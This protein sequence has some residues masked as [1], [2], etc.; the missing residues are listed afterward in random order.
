MTETHFLYVEQNFT[1]VSILLPPPYPW[2]VP[3]LCCAFY[4][5]LSGIWN[6]TGRR[7]SVQPQWLH[8]MAGTMA[9]NAERM[10]DSQEEYSTM[11]VCSSSVEIGNGG[12]LHHLRY[13]WVKTGLP[14]ALLK[15]SIS[16]D[17]WWQ[18][19][20][21]WCD[22]FVV[23]CCRGYGR[24]MECFRMSYSEQST[25]FMKASCMGWLSVFWN[26]AI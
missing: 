15:S 24:F 8:W 4:E 22:H 12:Y 7:A 16:P 10:Q 11:I 13:D 14:W 25:C 17:S 1:H 26:P 18:S 20:I 19:I 21:A 3:A 9:P 2:L 6:N 5:R 23:S